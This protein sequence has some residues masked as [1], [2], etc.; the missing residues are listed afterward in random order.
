MKKEQKGKGKVES[1]IHM[2]E[3]RA[4]K[5]I[6]MNEADRKKGIKGRQTKERK[7]LEKKIGGNI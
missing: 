5:R 7:K 2:V 3:R 1:G 6:Q 4:K